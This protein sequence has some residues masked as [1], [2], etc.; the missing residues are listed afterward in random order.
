MRLY[1]C[2][3]LTIYLPP[4]LE[5]TLD[6]S[7][8][9]TLDMSSILLEPPPHDQQEEAQVMCVEDEYQGMSPTSLIFSKTF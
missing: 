2:R 1:V 3:F 6:T 9:K 7:E 4:R 8:E 5:S